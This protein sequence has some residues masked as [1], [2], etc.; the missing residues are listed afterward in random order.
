MYNCFVGDGWFDRFQNENPIVMFPTTEES[1]EYFNE[2]LTIKQWVMERDIFI[3]EKNK[4]HSFWC[5]QGIFMMESCNLTA[6][7][8]SDVSFVTIVSRCILI[9]IFFNW[10]M[11]TLFTEKCAKL[12]DASKGEMFQSFRM[13]FFHKSKFKNM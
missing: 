6:W 1:V 13:F 3:L 8:K 12:F 9:F 11:F 5:T 10:L 4:V 7:D 2:K